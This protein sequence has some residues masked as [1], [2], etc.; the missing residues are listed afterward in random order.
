MHGEVIARKTAFLMRTLLTFPTTTS[1]CP[2]C[3]DSPPPRV[4]HP[5]NCGT[6]QRLWPP[7]TKGP[8]ARWKEYDGHYI[9][10]ARSTIARSNH[11]F[12]KCEG[13]R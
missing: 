12:V 4:D 9:L 5:F 2:R 3:V 10:K 13:E 11:R 1:K 8:T 6:R 7:T